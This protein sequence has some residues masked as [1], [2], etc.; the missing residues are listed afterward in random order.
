MGASGM[1]HQAPP[2]PLASDQLAFLF[3]TFLAVL[4]DPARNQTSFIVK[5][6][7]VSP[8]PFKFWNAEG[9]WD[10]VLV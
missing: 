9:R 2:E 3:T 7:E 4:R 6:P 5:L 10:G 1:G 8:T